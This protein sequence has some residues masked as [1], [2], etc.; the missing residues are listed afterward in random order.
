MGYG[1]KDTPWHETY[2]H[3]DGERR[4]NTRCI[5]F[6]HI[7]RK[8]GFCSI[9]GHRCTG[10]SHCECYKE[11]ND[12]HIP[13]QQN[14]N[15]QFYNSQPPNLPTIKEILVGEKISSPKKEVGEIID[16]E[17]TTLYVKMFDE[18]PNNIRKVGFSA[19]KNPPIGRW[20]AVDE[21]IQKFILYLLE[22]EQ[23]KHWRSNK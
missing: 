16:I 17:G 19:L 14:N 15:E 6:I 22:T 21:D 23:K 12:V 5:H 20:F 8:S 18:I 11:K 1:I 10:S 3:L 2:L 4:Q 7:K 13:S 9:R